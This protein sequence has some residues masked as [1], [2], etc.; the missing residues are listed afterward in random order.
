MDELLQTMS[1][2]IIKCDFLNSDVIN[3]INKKVNILLE[4][5]QNTNIV[6]NL[7]DISNWIELYDLWTNIEQFCLNAFP[8]AMKNMYFSHKTYGGVMISNAPLNVEN[9]QK[10]H[11]DTEYKSYTVCIPLVPVNEKNGCTQILPNTV[12]ARPKSWKKYYS[13]LIN[14]ECDLGNIVIFDGRI[15]HRG[16]KN[17]SE[18][19][20]PII[21]GTMSAHG[22]TNDFKLQ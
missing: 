22:F 9:H 7:H 8:N 4:E 3:F 21:I 20:R 1:F 10:W 13:T 6:R 18:R 11:R 12:K 14:M 15:L 2:C 19:N 5:N 17:T 16:L